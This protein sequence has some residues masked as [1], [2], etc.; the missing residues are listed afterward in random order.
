[1]TTREIRLEGPG[2]HGTSVN[3]ALLR[4]LLDLVIG[5]TQRA[6]RLRTQGR[7]VAQ[8]AQLKWIVAATEMDIQL[9]EGSTVVAFEVPTLLEAD[10][11]EFR[12][13][14]LFPEIDPSL[15]GIDYLA[16]SIAAVSA[17]DK[18]AQQYD[19]PFLEHLQGFG[20]VLSHG[21]EKITFSGS[22]ASTG[23]SASLTRDTLE[24][25]S[26]MQRSIAPPQEVMLAG[27]LDTIRAS[28]RTFMISLPS[29]PENVRGICES[30]L[31]ET[32][33]A[34][35]TRDVVVSGTAH[36]SSGGRVLRIET[37][38]LREATVSDVALWGIRPE[39]LA[40]VPV[41]DVFRVAQGPRSGLNAI[42]GQWPGDETDEAIEA[43]LEA[44]S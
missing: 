44:T 5:G 6:L 30:D 2:A 19:T 18:Q 42:I 21:I 31:V 15:T 16:S 27:K 9:R 7:S 38:S 10:P 1:M 28:D 29:S 4:D 41:P 33:R 43:L 34:L 11:L 32:L 36:Y 25:I 26:G 3:A 20:K 23:V 22:P 13:S 17:S 8:G 24:R 39:P 14:G 37:V 40:S 12:Q 35:W